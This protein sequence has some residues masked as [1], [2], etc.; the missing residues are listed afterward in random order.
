M[1]WHPFAEQ[2]PYL[3]GQEW[4]DFLA[5]I[6]KTK[7][8]ELKVYFRTVNGIK[9]GLDGRNRWRACDK[10]N[11]HCNME[12]VFLD[13]AEAIDFIIRRNIKRR[14]ITPEVR[15]SIVATLTN[16]GK[17]QRQI[18]ATIGSSK[19]TVQRDQQAVA[20]TPNGGGGPF[21]PPAQ[22]AQNTAN[23][24]SLVI[25]AQ[26]N[27]AA[28][29]APARRRKNTPPAGQSSDADESVIKDKSGTIVPEKCRAAFIAAKSFNKIST[30]LNN[31]KNLIA[32]IISGD[33]G[34]YLKGR[35]PHFETALNNTRNQ[36]NAGRPTHIC[37][38]CDAKKSNCDCCK[39]CGWVP[40]HVYKTSPSGD[41]KAKK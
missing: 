19:A 35:T 16:Q 29:P 31:A 28:E 40:L 21:G 5:S 14:H 41:K 18:A 22:L 36:V 38:Y 25:G 30:L 10:L 12:E 26:S 2:F 34:H 11:L 15:Q 1:K 17:S 24:A 27:T 23:G 32:G 13:D 20:T 3:E 6:N 8:N 4:D 7:G 39:G 9:E 37:P 33:A